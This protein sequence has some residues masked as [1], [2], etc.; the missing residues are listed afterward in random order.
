[1]TDE[2][3][4]RGSQGKRDEDRYFLLPIFEMIQRKSSRSPQS[5]PVL[6]NNMPLIIADAPK[7]ADR[8]KSHEG[9]MREMLPNSK[10]LATGK[11]PHW[12]LEY[13]ECFFSDDVPNWSTTREEEN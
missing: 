12:Q 5:F 4:T 10:S 3:G 7:V 2:R 6:S 9:F 13:P 8:R 1:M 11:I